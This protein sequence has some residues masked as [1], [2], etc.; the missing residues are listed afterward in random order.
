MRI[1]ASRKLCKLLFTVFSLLF[2]D[3]DLVF[4]GFYE[5][6][7]TGIHLKTNEK[8]LKLKTTYLMIKQN[9]ILD[10]YLHLV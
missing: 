3:N 7:Y 2:L 1:R 8:K 6:L 4:R 5:K 9:N 10:W